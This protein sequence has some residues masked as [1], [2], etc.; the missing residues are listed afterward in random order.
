MP[1]GNAQIA[2][3]VEC[4]CSPRTYE[5]TFDFSLECEPIN[6]DLDNGGILDA[7]CLVT[8]FDSINVTN[9]V[10]VAVSSVQLIEIGEDGGPVAVEQQTGDF[11]DGATIIYT[12]ISSQGAVA[13][14]AFELRALG[15][16]DEGESL[17]LQWAVT[18][19]NNC[20]VYPVITEN[21]SIGWTIF[22]GLGR[23]L[24]SAC[25][26]ATATIAPTAK[27]PT[28]NPTKNPST[29]GSPTLIPTNAPALNPTSLPT[30][31]DPSTCTP[32]RIQ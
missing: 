10:P 26:A 3:T 30:I 28:A 9:L 6:V 29:K 14:K 17:V 11:R 1:T 19:S 2:G 12:S 15:R 31:T 24:G 8:G 16:N 23:P 20:A 32:I 27:P 18:F 22:T 4:V 25:P 7:T 5:L 21:D 13:P